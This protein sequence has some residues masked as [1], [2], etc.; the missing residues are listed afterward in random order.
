MRKALNHLGIKGHTLKVMW[1]RSRAQSLVVPASQPAAPVVPGLP[2]PIPL[3]P[4]QYTV[5]KCQYA[6]T[7]IHMF[8]ACRRCPQA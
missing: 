7:I 6:F 2:G 5:R 1:G 4:Q 3:P 8:R